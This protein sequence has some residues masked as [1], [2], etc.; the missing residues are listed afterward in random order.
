MTTKRPLLTYQNHHYGVNSY[1]FQGLCSNTRISDCDGGAAF[2]IRV[3]P[4]R[5]KALCDKCAKRYNPEHYSQIIQRQIE[6]KRGR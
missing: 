6:I 5:F 1:G 3:G 2:E 4:N